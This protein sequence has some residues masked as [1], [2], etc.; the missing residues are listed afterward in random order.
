[1]ADAAAIAPASPPPTPNGVDF[2]MAQTTNATPIIAPFV[3]NV[4]RQEQWRT[5]PPLPLPAHPPPLT[6]WISL[7]RK[8]PWYQRLLLWPKTCKK[9]TAVCR[10]MPPTSGRHQTADGF[11]VAASGLIVCAVWAK[12]LRLVSILAK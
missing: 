10:L 2:I 4:P 5:L 8:Q 12:A 6:G 11:K 9:I 7:W 3:P 1:M